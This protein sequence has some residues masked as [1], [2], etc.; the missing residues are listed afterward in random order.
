MAQKLLLTDDVLDLGRKGEIVSV[1]N[2][3]ARNYLLPRGLGIVADA[4]A[5]RRQAIL[6]EERA[7]QAVI[8]LKE[9][10][11]QAEKLKGIIL[12]SVVKVDPEGRMYGS[13]T[14]LDIAHL[15]K[16]QHGFEMDRRCIQLK[17]PI[18]QTGSHKIDLKLK[19]GVQATVTLKIIPEK[20]EDRAAAIAAAMEEEV[21]VV[22]EIAE[23][24]QA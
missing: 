2:G 14:H 16:E 10:E 4:N 15:F 12:V 19:E 9:A 3:Y 22:Q 20:G 24:P 8:D 7:K 6:Q 5:L 17:H 21:P 11:E 18:K 1:R 13:V 23:E